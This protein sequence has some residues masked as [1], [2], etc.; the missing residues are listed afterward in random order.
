MKIIPQKVLLFLLFLTFPLWQQCKISYSTSGAS[1]PPDARTVSI[2][3]F[4]N[5]APIVVP[6]LSTTFTESLKDKFISQTSLDLINGKGDLHFEGEIVDYN[7]QP[8]NI[9]GNERAAQNRLT[10]AVKVTFIN[11]KAPK[12][13]FENQTFSRYADYSSTQELSAV[14]NQLI[15]EIV[16][17]LVQDI[18]NKSV[19]NW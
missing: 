11:Q 6:N 14:E 3:Y 1:I 9:Q 16:E 12:F 18:F 7:T 13:N 5:R 4:Q 10:I 15:D 19:V 2:D 8:I 17:Q